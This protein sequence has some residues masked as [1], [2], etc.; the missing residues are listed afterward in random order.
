MDGLART[1]HE[2]DGFAVD[3]VPSNRPGVYIILCNNVVNSSSF[4]GLV[5][6]RLRNVF[7]NLKKKG[8]VIIF[9]G[10]YTIMVTNN[11]G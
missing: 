6:C 11:N 3:F 5:G 7:M 2:R 1:N 8:I 10:V 4:L 9:P